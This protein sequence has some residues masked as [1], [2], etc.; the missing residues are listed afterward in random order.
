[1]YKSAAY[2]HIFYFVLEFELSF[3][4][5]QSA[6]SFCVFI[7]IVGWPQSAFQKM[8]NYVNIRFSCMDRAL[9]GIYDSIVHTLKSHCEK[10]QERKSKIKSTSVSK[11]ICSKCSEFTE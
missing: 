2:I 8:I 11:F 6:L 5:F 7:Y 10:E 1:M 4:S 9:S 3:I